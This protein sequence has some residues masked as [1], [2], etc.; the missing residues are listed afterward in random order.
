M[1]CKIGFKEIEVAY[2]S[3]SDQEYEFVRGLIDNNEIPDDVAI[4][5]SAC[6][7]GSGAPLKIALPLDNHPMPRGSYQTLNRCP[8]WLEE[9]NYSPL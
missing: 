7:P 8:R 4:Q 9:G 2:P 1:L 5:V 3:S 6:P